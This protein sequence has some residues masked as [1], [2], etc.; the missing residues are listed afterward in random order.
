MTI[1]KK[2]L[3]ALMLAVMMAVGN[4]SVLANENNRAD[5][6]LPFTDISTTAW[7]YD[8][9]RTVWEHD[10]FTGTSPTTFDPQGTMT[11]AMFVQVLANM[12]SVDLSAYRNQAPTFGDTLPTQWYFAAVEWAA[13]QGLVSGVGNGNFAPS[14]AITRQEMAVMLNNYITSRNI[15]IPQAQTAPFTDQNG[16]SEW[17]INAVSAIQSAGIISGHPD[18]RFAPQDTATRAEVATIFARYIEILAALDEL[19]SQ[20][21]EQHEEVQEDYDN[22]EDNEDEETEYFTLTIANITGQGSVFGTVTI[23]NR[24]AV[25]YDFP[26]GTSVTARATAASGYEFDG[27]FSNA[28][29]TGTAVSRNRNFAFTITA[30]TNLFARFRAE[31]QVDDSGSGNGNGGSYTPTPPVFVAVT[32]VTLSSPTSIQEGVPLTL[33]ATVVPNNATNQTITWSVQNTGGTGA[34]ITSGNVLNTASAGTVTVRATITNGATATANFTQDFSI[35]VTATPPVFVPVTNITGVDTSNITAG[36]TRNLS[37]TV[38]PNNATNQIIVWSVQNAGGTGATITGGNVLNTA[39]AGTVTVRATVVNGATATTDYTQDFSIT[40]TA[41]PTFTIT[42]NPNNG[43]VS[44]TSGITGTDGTLS[45]LPTPSRTGYIFDG[46]FTAATGGTAV[47]TSTVF[48]ANTTIFAQWILGATVAQGGTHQWVFE[49]LGDP[50]VSRNAITLISSPNG[51]TIDRTGQDEIMI[52]VA[53]YTNVGTHTITV[54]VTYL[55]LTWAPTDYDFRLI[56]V[57]P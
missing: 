24:N 9:V 48:T 56:V 35:T 32:G 6:P 51:V 41:I 28:N 31:P 52:N 4:I 54:R 21:I 2:R 34:T 5:Q 20:E 18:G 23:V 50:L 1:T 7:Y 25:T 11:R 12:E 40:V 8:S 19:A 45:T 15:E 39:T 14:R 55:G 44:P 46:W 17:A 10:L 53:S 26:T 49:P 42:F 29:G 30:D 43:T 22:D 13:S 47:T 27:W 33:S 16:I 36:Q 57:A 37:G 3:L 38:V